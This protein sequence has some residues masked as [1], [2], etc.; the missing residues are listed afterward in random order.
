MSN[1]LAILPLEI[2]NEI[3]SY[4]KLLDFISFAH[5]ARLFYN[6]VIPRIHRG[7]VKHIF[8][9]MKVIYIGPPMG[10]RFFEA[11]Q[12]VLEWAAGKGFARLAD[13]ILGLALKGRFAYLNYRHALKL[14]AQRGLRPT[15]ELLF[16]K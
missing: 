16:E 5:T 7:A 1:L 13:S 12:T 14:A 3:A 9:E 4:L 10:S 6:I 2:M 15:V 11:E 8:P